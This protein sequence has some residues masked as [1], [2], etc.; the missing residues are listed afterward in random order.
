MV[1]L[2]AV[3]ELK[4]FSITIT[5]LQQ[6]NMKEWYLIWHLQVVI[7]YL[8]YDDEHFLCWLKLS[9]LHCKQK[10]TDQIMLL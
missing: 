8:V 5:D 1:Q 2:H 3:R 10:Q 9:I 6:T 4:R 7:C